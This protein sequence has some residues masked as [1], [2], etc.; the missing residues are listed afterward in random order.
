GNIG[1]RS[2]RFS[3][4]A[5]SSNGSP[6]IYMGIQLQRS[7]GS[8]ATPQWANVS[9]PG[10]GWHRF[11]VDIE[12]T[13]PQSVGWRILYQLREGAGTNWR[14]HLWAPSVQL[15]DELAI[16]AKATA[17]QA[18]TVSTNNEQ[19]IASLTSSVN[20]QFNDLEAS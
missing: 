9:T 16:A 5:K 20:S 7:D 15:V 8:A 13:E 17:D 1:G 11:D 12:I 18:V 19:A 2:V 3:G 6:S 14:G 10:Q 4:W